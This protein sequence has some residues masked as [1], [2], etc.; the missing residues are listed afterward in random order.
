MKELRCAHL[1]ESN[2]LQ[3]ERRKPLGRGRRSPRNA[4]IVAK[5]SH[6][7]NPERRG[8]SVSV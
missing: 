5:L 3:A 4:V 1:G 8:G 6:S 2:D 7:L